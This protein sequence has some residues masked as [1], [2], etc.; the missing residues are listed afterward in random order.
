MVTR[1][2]PSILLADDDIVLRD[3]LSFHFD[4]A[5]MAVGV[6]ENGINL[7]KEIGEE[8]QVCIV[9]LNMPGKRGMDCLKSIKKNH[10]GVE[11]I[12]LTNVNAAK[13]AL[14]AMRIGAFDYITKPFDPDE[15]I[16]SVRKAMQLSKASKD[17][18]E[19]RNSVGYAPYKS[20]VLGESEA[21]IKV[22]KLLGRI[23]PSDNSVLLTGESGTGKGLIARELH[24]Q[25]KRSGG[26]FITVSCPSLPKD[27]LESEMFG[28]EKGAFTGA[29]ARR[30]GRVE[31]ANKGTL[32]LDEIGEMPL[33]LQP[34]LLNFLQ[35]KTFFRVGGEK[36]HE[37]D[38]RV[39]A[40]TNMNLE[41]AVQEGRF[42]ED[43]YFRLNILPI[44]LP[45]LRERGDDV[46]RL[47][48]HFIER[49]A[50]KEKMTVPTLSAAA[51]NAIQSY[52]WPGNVRQ[53]ENA[54][55]RAYLLRLDNSKL[56]LGD[57]QSDIIKG[58]SGKPKEVSLADMTLEE[59]EKQAIVQTME[60]CKGNKAET[61]RRLGISEKSVYNKMKR[62]GL[63]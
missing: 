30:L 54:I 10:F 50:K 14:D 1:K 32:F 21:M 57:F 38:V 2:P 8:T 18:V 53:L 6:F 52:F 9:D 37:A 31:L 11:V 45:A 60:A 20:G 35:E 19:I 47:A 59:I 16:L 5:G 40:A 28:H 36:Q 55:E 3:L 63:S 56:D 58:V 49:A 42:R 39:I 43:L 23:A 29:V 15:V 17:V 12:I 51:Q 25:S 27:I 33:E 34:K 22:M 41:L 24:A 7:L 62:H 26:P 13:E 61:A 44:E 48:H 4:R 46:L